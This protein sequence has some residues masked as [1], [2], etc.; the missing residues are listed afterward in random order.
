MPVV[1]KSYFT[2]NQWFPNHILRKPG[3][4][5]SYFAL[6]RGYQI[7]FCLIR[8]LPNHILRKPGVTKS[9]LALSRGYQIQFNGNITYLWCN[10]Y[11]CIQYVHITGGTIGVKGGGETMSIFSP[12][13]FPTPT[14]S[15]FS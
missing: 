10:V 7:I 9:Y 1:S 15:L 3:V 6:S 5:K 13:C 11:T 12:S 14:P 2:I 8:G 4:T